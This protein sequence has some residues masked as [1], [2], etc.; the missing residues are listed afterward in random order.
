M[1]QGKLEEP[2]IQARPMAR[3]GLLHHINCYFAAEIS[4]EIWL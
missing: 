4:G 2:P 3:E 1:P